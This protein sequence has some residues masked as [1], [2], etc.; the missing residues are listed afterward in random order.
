MKKSFITLGP[1]SGP[2]KNRGQNLLLTFNIV[3]YTFFKMSYK[4]TKNTFL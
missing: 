2:T 4:H 3:I 1:G